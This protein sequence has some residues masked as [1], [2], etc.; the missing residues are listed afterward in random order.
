LLGR[1]E[2]FAQLWLFWV[3]PILGAIAAGGLYLAVFEESEPKS[4]AAPELSVR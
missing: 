1:P 3:A 4:L 2:L